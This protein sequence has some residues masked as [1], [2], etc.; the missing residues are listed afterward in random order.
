MTGTGMGLRLPQARAPKGE[1]LDDTPQQGAAQSQG[2]MGDQAGEHGVWEIK[3]EWRD[4]GGTAD[5]RPSSN[6]ITNHSSSK[7]RSIMA[8]MLDS[9]GR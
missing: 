6:Q 7:K 3:K 2:G 4:G 9:L 1:A 8:F 5:Q